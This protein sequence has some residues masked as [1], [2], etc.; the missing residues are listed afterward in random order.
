MCVGCPRRSELAV[1]KSA[2]LC[3]DQRIIKLRSNLAATCKSTAP[4]RT[5]RG[6]SVTKKTFWIGS[7]AP[8][9]AGM[10]DREIWGQAD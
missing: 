8:V 10:V 3:F 4:V 2:Y 9:L 5:E 7:V 6:G 1:D